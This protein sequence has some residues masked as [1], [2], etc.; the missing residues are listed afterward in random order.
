LTWLVY[1]AQ[2]SVRRSRRNRAP[3]DRPVVEI[4]EQADRHST[5]DALLQSRFPALAVCMFGLFGGRTPDHA[6]TV[7]RPPAPLKQ[8]FQICPV[9]LIHFVKDQTQILVIV[10]A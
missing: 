1:P 4:T 2:S 10:F 7:V 8:L 9:V 6:P 5:L 3:G